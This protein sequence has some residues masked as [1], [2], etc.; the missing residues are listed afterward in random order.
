MA[1]AAAAALAAAP[2]ASAADAPNTDAAIGVD[3]ALNPQGSGTPP[4]GTPQPLAIGQ[5]I[6]SD[7]RVATA[8]A[9]QAQLLF[10]DGS[11]LSVGPASDLVIDR[12]VYDPKAGAGQLAMSATRGVFRFI[13]G[14][15]SKGEQPVTLTTPAATI[16]VRGGIFMARLG[17][18]GDLT[19]VFLY[20]KELTVTG[21]NGVVTVVRRPGFAVRVDRAGDSPSGPFQA[22]RELL[23]A[24]LGQFDG[25]VATR[26]AAAA[27]SSG[28]RTAAEPL[29]ARLAGNVDV[30]RRAE[31][32]PTS[33]LNE[34]LSSHPLLGA[35]GISTLNL[36]SV[37]PQVESR[38]MQAIER[39]RQRRMGTR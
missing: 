15:I 4:G 14:E 36:N 8:V 13:G 6:V 5:G 1:M 37:S 24:F 23:E 28:S 31:L 22:P 39:F 20:G 26:A 21:R 33:A 34:L 32:F 12:F 11:A 18:T 29:F 17:P 19:V 35:L 7:E 10:R 27:G 30:A 16:G 3:A 9:G 2:G 38:L 25:P